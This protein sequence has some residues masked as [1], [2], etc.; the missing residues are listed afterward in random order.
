M[1]KINKVNVL[2]KEYTITYTD[3]FSQVDIFKRDGMLGQVDYLTH[4]IRIY[5]N[6]SSDEEVFSTLL[7]EI[8]HI[9][10]SDLKVKSLGG[11]YENKQSVNQHE[12]LDLIALALTDTLYRNNLLKN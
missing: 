1:E 7:H 10:I 12:D 5:D 3:V 6:G 9:I 4:S 8:L 2:G 11:G